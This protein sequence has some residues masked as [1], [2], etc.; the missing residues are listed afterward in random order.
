MK[1]ITFDCLTSRFDKYH[2]HQRNFQRPEHLNRFNNKVKLLLYKKRENRR[3]RR[4]LEP[5]K[6]WQTHKLNFK[7]G[8]LRLVVFEQSK[9]KS[10]MKKKKIKI[11]PYHFS[12]I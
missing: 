12:C 5:G 11:K 8:S 4:H 3:H 1:H 10:F 7:S 9:K 6:K 2:H